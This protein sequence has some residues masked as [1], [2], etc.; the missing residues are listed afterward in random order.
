M[1]LVTES[2]SKQ[3][4]EQLLHIATIG[5]TVGIKGDLKFHI[6]TD[7]PEQF[8]DGST[9][10]IGNNEKIT[11][12]TV[13]LE[14]LLV[15]VNGVTDSQ[16]AKIFTNVKLYTSREESRKN[17]KLQKGEYFWFDLEDCQVYEDAKLLGVVDE[18]ERIGVTNYLSIITDESLVK[19]GFAKSFLVPFIE[20]FKKDVDIDKKVITLS[21]A[22]DILEAS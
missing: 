11:L 3:F 18:I 15:K 17:C 12:T 21:G 6:K 2:M 16:D 20:P 4:K 1:V 19:D 22:L 8:V 5:K 7:F 10:F 14:R 9:F 13:D